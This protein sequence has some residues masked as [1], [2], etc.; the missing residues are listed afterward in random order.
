MTVLRSTLA[1]FYEE[2]DRKLAS[3]GRPPSRRPKS[4]KGQDA[5]GVATAFLLQVS[6]PP[7]S[8]VNTDVEFNLH[9]SD[10]KVLYLVF[11][12]L[13]VAV[14]SSACTSTQYG[15]L[16]DIIAAVFENTYFTFFSDFKKRALTFFQLTL[17]T[18]K[19]VSKSLVLNPS[20]I[21]WLLYNIYVFIR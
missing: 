8:T 19:V 2:L 3:A 21:C 14:V 5:D 18:L 20:F 15:I 11:H 17:E 9:K 10:E 13:L 7:L 16:N 4:A 12:L 6:H 1:D